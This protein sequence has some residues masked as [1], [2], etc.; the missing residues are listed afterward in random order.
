MDVCVVFALRRESMCFR[1]QFPSHLRVS[2][3]PF[4]VHFCGPT[5][6]ALLVLETGVGGD[7]ATSAI[8]W[9]LSNPIIGNVPYR[10]RLILSAGFSGALQEGQ[11]VGDLVM[12]TEV[13]DADGTVWPATWPVGIGA[14][15]ISGGRLLCLSTLVGNPEEKRRLGRESMAV[16]VDMESGHLAKACHR[17]GVLFGALRVISDD[18]A[19]PLSPRLIDV[20]KNGRVSPLRLIGALIRSPCLIGELW[21]LRGATQHAAQQLAAGLR[22]ILTPGSPCMLDSK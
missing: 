12:A 20:L 2:G 14:T 8:N 13:V 19:T 5:A 17:A 7:A 3:A 9:V 18:L 21:R 4:P 16:A 15:R 10:P 6:Q 22:E 11:R 1:R